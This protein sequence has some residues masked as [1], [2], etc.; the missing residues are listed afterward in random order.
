MNTPQ[1]PAADEPHKDALA[2]AVHWS[3]LTGLVLGS[4]LLCW[5]LVISMLRNEHAPQSPP[6]AVSDLLHRAMQD[7]GPALLQLGILLLLFTPV[8]RV[9]VL[10]VGWAIRRDWRMAAVAVT[11]LALLAVSIFLSAR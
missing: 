1:T 5:G 8:V 6:P 4:V 2:R 11:V 10:A 3:L 7:E 9:L